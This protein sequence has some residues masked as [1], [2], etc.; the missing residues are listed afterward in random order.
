MTAE[1][2]NAKVISKRAFGRLRNL[3]VT[4]LGHFEM[5]F[6]AI[7]KSRSLKVRTPFENFHSQN[8]R[9]LVALISNF[10]KYR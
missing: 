10:K 4:F 7:E 9:F 1:S 6:R 2:Y 3:K 5:S 8:M